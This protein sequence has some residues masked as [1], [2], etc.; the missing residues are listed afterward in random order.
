MNLPK[1]KRIY[2]PFCKKHTIHKIAIVKGKERGSFKHG[3]I[4]RA[5][6]RGRGVGYGNL[7][8][9]GSKPALSKFKRTGAKSSKKTNLKY[10][11]NECKKTHIQNKGIRAKKVEFK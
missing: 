4:S 1:Q 3:S 9:W 7:G 5:K 6:K 8:K 11:C 2:C 10:T